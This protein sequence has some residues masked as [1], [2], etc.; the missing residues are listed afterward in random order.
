[1]TI[2]L[3]K[4]FNFVRQ[5]AIHERQIIQ[6]KFTNLVAQTLQGKYDLQCSKAGEELIS[7]AVT[8]TTRH[9]MVMCLMSLPD[10]PVPPAWLIWS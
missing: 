6:R 8:M 9:N 7:R 2:Y 10:T 3:N 1:M 5:K 4:S